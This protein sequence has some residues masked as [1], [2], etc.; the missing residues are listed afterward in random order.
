M[1]TMH[2]PPMTFVAE[3]PPVKRRKP[4]QQYA[5]AAAELSARPGVWA[6]VARFKKS[7]GNKPYS[8]SWAIKQGRNGFGGQPGVYAS[9]VR[10]IDGGIYVVCAQR[11]V[12]SWGDR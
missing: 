6:I 1:S 3:L 8:L 7:D 11:L 2:R 10:Q 9:A 4:S 12:D 5:A